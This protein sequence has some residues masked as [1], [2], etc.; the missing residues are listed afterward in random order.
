MQLRQ[1]KRIEVDIPV[2]IVTVLETVEASIVDITECG[3]QIHGLALPSGSRFRI[4]YRGETIFA[5]CQWSEI[6]RMGIKFL[7]ELVDGP[8]HERLMMARMSEPVDDMPADMPLMTPSRA[9]LA[10]RTFA[11]AMPGGSFGRRS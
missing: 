9:P 2:T 1:T 11:R 10:A 3:A 5:I 8:L 4:E 6:D 7:F